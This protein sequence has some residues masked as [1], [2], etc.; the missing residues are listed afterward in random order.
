MPINFTTATTV[1]ANDLITRAARSLGYL[2]RTESIG[3]ADTVDA[4]ETLNALL[5]SWSAG[6]ILMAVICELSSFPLA[7]GQ[8]TCTIGT[9]GEVV[10]ARPFDILQA[11]VRDTNNLDYPVAIVP[12]NVW[13][14]IGNKNISS[15]IPNTLFY[16]PAYP[17]GQINIFPKPILPYTLFYVNSLNQN[18][19]TTL[20]QMLAMPLGYERALIQNLA[21]EMITA[22]FPCMLGAA[23]LALLI[24]TAKES[25]A[26]VKRANMKEVIS[27]Y[28]PLIVARS[29]ATYNIFSD[30]NPR[31]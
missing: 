17:L 3:A 14:N 4:L 16:Q 19:F 6:E 22:G 12:Q 18:Q 13:N 26:N 1:T 20:T 27:D 11:F 9:G 25:K 2:G 7:S 28:D 31:R 5:D 24:A 30:G 29:Y 15:Q 10:H 21:V 8:Q 23:Q